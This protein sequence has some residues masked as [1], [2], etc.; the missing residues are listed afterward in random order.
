[1]KKAVEAKS[2]CVPLFIYNSFN[3]GAFCIIVAAT[4]LFNNII[5]MHSDSA[6]IFLSALYMY[7][8]LTVTLT[9]IQRSRVPLHIT[10]L[11]QQR[12][13]RDEAVGQQQR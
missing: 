1:M 2:Y 9:L 5:T 11:Q 13:S 10:S 3:L 6:I 12:G 7:I 8:L 4:R